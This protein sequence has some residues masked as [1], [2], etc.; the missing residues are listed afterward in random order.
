[1]FGEYVGAVF[2]LEIAL[3]VEVCIALLI[4]CF[5]ITILKIVYMFYYNACNIPPDSIGILPVIV[6]E[7]LN[8]WKSKL[9][10]IFYDMSAFY[11]KRIRVVLNTFKAKAKW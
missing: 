3:A 6:S 7:K 10:E 4:M 5:V 1:L 11:G 2:L 9:M 8:S